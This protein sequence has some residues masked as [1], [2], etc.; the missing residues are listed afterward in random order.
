MLYDILGDIA[1]R[2]M[3]Y[4]DEPMSDKSM[5]E[6]TVVDINDHMLKVGEERANSQGLTQG[7][8]IVKVCA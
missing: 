3:K 4:A 2:Y 1:F 7:L 5:R 8:Y 6:V